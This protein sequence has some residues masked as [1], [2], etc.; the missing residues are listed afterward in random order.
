MSAIYKGVNTPLQLCGPAFKVRSPG[1]NE[2]EK[3]A[4]VYQRE[5]NFSIITFKMRKNFMSKHM[6]NIA[7]M[8]LIHVLLYSTHWQCID[9]CNRPQ[10]EETYFVLRLSRCPHFEDILRYIYTFSLTIG[11]LNLFLRGWKSSS[12]VGACFP[13]LVPLSKFQKT[14]YQ[15]FIQKILQLCLRIWVSNVEIKMAMQ[16]TDITHNTD[17]CWLSSRHVTHLCFMF[18]YYILLW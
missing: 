14:K 7:R 3:C 17:L 2:C 8:K 5:E 6:Q 13:N 10:I 15:Q 11:V 12:S 1:W 18:D 4:N 9:H 16:L